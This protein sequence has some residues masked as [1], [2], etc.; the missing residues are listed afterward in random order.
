MKHHTPFV[1]LCIEEVAFIPHLPSEI[2]THKCMQVH[3]WLKI[4][5]SGKTNMDYPLSP[6]Q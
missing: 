2:N 3:H 4:S 5:A 1:F 6:P